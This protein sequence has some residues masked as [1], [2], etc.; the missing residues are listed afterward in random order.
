MKNA[1]M[2]ILAVLLGF[3][4]FLL[5]NKDNPAER[6]LRSQKIVKG[7]SVIRYIPVKVP[8][9]F[10]VYA[11]TVKIKVPP[12]SNCIAEYIKLHYSFTEHKIYKDTLQNDSS[13]LIV[14]ID[15][16]SMNRLIGRTYGFLNKRATLIQITNTYEAI[17]LKGWLI[18]FNV[19]KNIGSLSLYY[20]YNKSMFSAGYDLYQ[21]TPVFGCALRL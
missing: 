11:D 20:I 14:V 8:V 17:K 21:K 15:T 10:K 5:I 12:D 18:G 3:V 16:V 2:I 1:V 7:D 6:I 4:T 19:G 13:A 9:P